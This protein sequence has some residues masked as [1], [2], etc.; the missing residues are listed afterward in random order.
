[1]FLAAKSHNPRLHN[2]LVELV[3]GGL[4]EWEYLLVLVSLK[5]LAL[6]LLGVLPQALVHQFL[7]LDWVYL[8]GWAGLVVFNLDQIFQRVWAGFG[9][10]LFA[11]ISTVWF[12]SSEAAM[13]RVPGSA[14]GIDLYLLFLNLILAVRI[15]LLNP[16]A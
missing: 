16:G 2:G 6:V 1:M 15:L 8:L 10:A 7:V 4:Q 13:D 5:V 3:P 11:G 12:S 9:V 14:L